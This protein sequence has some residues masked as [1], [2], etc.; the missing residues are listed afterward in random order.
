M[1]IPKFHFF[2]V[3]REP[4]FGDAMELNEPLLSVTPE[5]F[6]AIDI[7]LAIAKVFAMVKIDMPVA[8]EHKRIILLNLSV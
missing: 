1:V 2:Q 7:D 3:Q 4:F 8:T 5:P 6:N